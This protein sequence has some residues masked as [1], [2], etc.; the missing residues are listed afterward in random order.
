M[1]RILAAPASRRLGRAGLEALA[2]PS[3]PIASWLPPLPPRPLPPP[4]PSR[5]TRHA[6]T[7]TV[8]L[9]LS[10]TPGTNDSRGRGVEAAAK[11]PGAKRPPRSGPLGAALRWSECARILAY[12]RAVH[13]KIFFA[14]RYAPAEHATREALRASLRPRSASRSPS[15]PSR[16]ARDHCK[17]PACVCG[18][19]NTRPVANVCCLTRGHSQQKF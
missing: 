3:P 10:R 17:R 1:S 9:L 7:F 16:L 19:T 14:A 15:F 5:V 11:R 4:L 8:L 6:V 12:L 2:P 18:S 13:C